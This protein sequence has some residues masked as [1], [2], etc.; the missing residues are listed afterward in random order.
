MEKNSIKCSF[1]DHIEIEAVIYCQECKVYLCNKCHNFHS[2]LCEN[3]HT[4]KLDK[5]L[6]EIFTGFC[7]EEKHSMELNYFCKAHNQLC[8]AACIAKIKNKGDG[9]HKDCDVCTIE[10]IKN[11]K[12]NNLKEN[13]KLLENISNNLEQLIKDLKNIFIKMNQNKEELK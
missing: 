12:Q 3:H 13:I 6:N 8:C 10:E 9:Q 2:K 5:N 4:Y 11:E 1:K 7:K